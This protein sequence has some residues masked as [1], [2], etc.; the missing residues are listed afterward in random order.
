MVVKLYLKYIVAIM[1]V[2]IYTSPVPPNLGE[3]EGH[4]YTSQ[5]F[6]Y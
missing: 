2:A 5:A 4:G 6:F 1:L 3:A